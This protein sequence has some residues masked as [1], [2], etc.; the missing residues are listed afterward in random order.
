MKK[1]NIDALMVH[2]DHT[3]RIIYNNIQAYVAAYLCQKEV[4]AEVFLSESIFPMDKLVDEM[5]VMKPQCIIFYCY[6]QNYRL[7]REAAKRITEKQS[8][9]TPLIAMG[10]A[11]T[12]ACDILPLLIPEINSYVVNDN[13]EEIYSLILHM[14]NIPYQS[15]YT[16][17]HN[18]DVYPS[19]YLSGLI[20]PVKCQK[21]NK[22]V[23]L[24]MTRGCHMKCKYC[25][26]S[27]MNGCSVRKHSVDR[28]INEVKY[29]LSVQESSGTKFDIKFTDE[30]F[31]ID[32]DMVF[33]FCNRVIEEG[34]N[35]KFSINT[36]ADNM[37]NEML[38]I[39][40]KAGCYRISYGLESAVP[41]ILE[42]M[43]KTVS[44]VDYINKFKQ[45]VLLTKKNG[46]A[47]AINTL[48][49]WWTETRE[50]A[51]ETLN[52]IEELN[53]DR[54]EHNILTYYRGTEAYDVVSK[55][56][57]NKSLSIKYHSFPMLYKYNP[58]TLRRL[59]IDN[60]N[61]YQQYQ[62]SMIQSLMG[63][64][65][66][67]KD[68]CQ[69]LIS[70][71]FDLSYEW[72]ARCVS[73]ATKIIFMQDSTDN[74]T[75]FYYAEEAFA[76]EAYDGDGHYV[77]EHILVTKKLLNSNN[78]FKYVE[79]ES[80]G[81]LVDLP[82]RASLTKFLSESKEQLLKQCI[83]FFGSRNGDI[84]I[85]DFCKIYEKSG[86]KACSLKRIII[87]SD[88][89]LYTCFHGKS[90]G[91]IS[92]LPNRELLKKRVIDTYNEMLQQRNCK[93]CEVYATCPKC[94]WPGNISTED[95]CAMQREI[96]QHKNI[97]TIY[98]A[99]KMKYCYN[100]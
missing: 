5:L 77:P 22:M 42:E 57:G 75:N 89:K 26:F 13:E 37:N 78:V 94:M 48:F 74:V 59:S 1:D 36:R 43:G 17:S 28:V 45:T 61:F 38:I 80:T 88:R 81:L 35:F 92:E 58:Y 6:D 51:E 68:Y 50:E 19:P 39:L 24:N 73:P 46:I 90:I 98:K 100:F 29:I 20:D 54:Y 2:F 11:A 14:K 96:R 23:V 4:N 85:K 79:N 21:L 67:D 99:I 86:C 32:R 7:V 66:Q 95:Y 30:F 55:I 93:N 82:N 41:H 16:P 91:E 65:Y 8:N 87:G 40:N 33:E 47:V 83:S 69:V 63:I 60:I 18:L 97:G 62:T 3:G 70:G 44:G 31:T 49:G 72:L 84:L 34:L 10:P 52:F 71:I 56:V 15:G 53:P 25:K 9:K 64:N 12:Y 27:A 76:G